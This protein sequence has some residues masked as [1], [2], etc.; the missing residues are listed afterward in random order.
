MKTDIKTQ[1]QKSHLLII[2]STITL[3]IITIGTLVFLFSDGRSSVKYTP[4]VLSGS[5]EMTGNRVETDTGKRLETLVNSG[6]NWGMSPFGS[7][8]P[9]TEEEKPE[10]KKPN[11]EWKSRSVTLSDGRT[12]YYE[13]GKGNPSGATP[14]SED[15][16]EAYKKCIHEPELSQI[17]CE[18]KDKQVNGYVSAELEKD[19]FT[20]LSH[21]NWRP[22]LTN[23]EQHFRK[24]EFLDWEVTYDKVIF[25]DIMNIENMMTIDT[26]SG[27]KELLY[28][29]LFHLEGWFKNALLERQDIR[30]KAILS[31]SNC[32]TQNGGFELYR[33]FDIVRQKQF[34]I[35]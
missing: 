15:E 14:L 33:L 35:D 2:M 7:G 17:S 3:G 4:I 13:F 20:L 23:C 9:L 1:S 28:G 10:F 24:Y 34:Y 8:K 16:K 29:K 21:P 31:I 26:E 27:R 6:S 11:T 19:L 12:L 22:I 18:S 25:G 32:I 5:T 30:G